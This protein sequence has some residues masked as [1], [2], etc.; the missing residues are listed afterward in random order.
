MSERAGCAV[1]AAQGTGLCSDTCWQ[2]ASAS[3]ALRQRR[4]W[5]CAIPA[6]APHTQKT[7]RW[8]H[9]RS[10]RAWRRAE[11]RTCTAGTTSDSAQRRT[12]AATRFFSGACEGE[13]RE[14]RF[15][16]PSG[17]FLVAAK[18]Q[19]SARGSVRPGWRPCMALRNAAGGPT[20]AVRAPFCPIQAFKKISLGGWL[21][22]TTGRQQ[23]I[24]L[25]EEIQAGIRRCHR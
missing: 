18:G 1:W 8:T 20:G 7:E 3:V 17:L 21:I 9:T 23:L 12:A 15:C 24:V 10:H 5:N 13:R 25:A 16:V 4:R 22:A 19:P 14:E 6:P 11:G 2:E